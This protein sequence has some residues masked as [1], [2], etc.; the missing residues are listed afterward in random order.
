MR[1][2]VW[3]YSTNNDGARSPAN[4]RFVDGLL[5]RGSLTAVPGVTTSVDQIAEQGIPCFRIHFRLPQVYHLT[6]VEAIPILVPSACVGTGIYR[7][8]DIFYALLEEIIAW[9][10]RVGPKSTLVRLYLQN[11]GQPRTRDNALDW[12][13]MH[14][15]FTWFIS[16]LRQA[17]GQF[18]GLG[19]ISGVYGVIEVAQAMTSSSHVSADYIVTLTLDNKRRM[20][21]FLPRSVA[22]LPKDWL[23][24]W[25]EV[26]NEFS[27]QV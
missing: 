12:Q 3:V 4:C 8:T 13:Q 10:A 15:G 6:R 18:P 22:Q 23:L 19:Q 20:S 26:Q 17:Y 16:S 25:L 21:L 5:H 9:L 27:L 14:N 2:R 1:L 11:H 7:P 24:D